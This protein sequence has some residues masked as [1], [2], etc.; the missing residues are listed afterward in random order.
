MTLT[1]QDK[2]RLRAMGIFVYCQF[3]TGECVVEHNGIHCCKTTAHLK[4]LANPTL[5]D[6]IR[7]FFAGEVA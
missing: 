6:R 5:L 3:S 1:P 2:Q 4:R 7:H